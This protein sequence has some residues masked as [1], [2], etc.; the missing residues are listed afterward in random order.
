MDS[1]FLQAI[2]PQAESFSILPPTNNWKIASWN[3][4]GIFSLYKQG[5][6]SH[7]LTK[8]NPTIILLSEIRIG[9]EKLYKCKGLH[10]MLEAL[11]YKYNYWH[12]MRVKHGG[13][14]GTALLSKIKPSKVVCGYSAPDVDTID[15]EG[16]IMNIIFPTFSIVHTYT[17]CSSWPEKKHQTPEQA[18]AKDN[19]RRQFDSDISRQIHHIQTKYALP[20]IWTG[21]RNCIDQDQ[22]VWH[23]DLA[24]PESVWAG[25]KKWE[26]RNYR[27]LLK[28]R[29][30]KDA[31][32][33]FC[34]DV[35]KPEYTYWRTPQ[36]WKFDE[37]WRLDHI[38]CSTELLTD[39]PH[40]HITKVN[41]L[42]EVPG[43][44]HCP[45]MAN[46]H[47]PHSIYCATSDPPTSIPTPDSRC[48]TSDPQTSI[49]RPNSLTSL[50]A[51]R[52]YIL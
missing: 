52:S 12:P 29:K 3:V 51:A 43:S 36:H 13:L 1:E 11:G 46:L 27:R 20:L 5:F 6:L 25:S 30:L 15:D 39:G 28:N 17:P 14:H 37:G 48:G 16:R 9:I 24:L 45:L 7:F 50:L 18:T 26:R 44:D 34:E 2:A 21:D 22:D 23:P 33:N 47:N 41:V 10:T 31:Y 42:R 8:H 49:S 4:N 38:V 35:T 19:I 32:L 40:S